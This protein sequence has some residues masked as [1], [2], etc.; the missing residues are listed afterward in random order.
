MV[1][2]TEEEF[3]DLDGCVRKMRT[4]EAA[5]ARIQHTDGKVEEYSDTTAEEWPWAPDD[6]PPEWRLFGIPMLKMFELASRLNDM[7]ISLLS[8]NGEI[9][10]KNRKHR[11]GNADVCR[12][13]GS[14]DGQ[15]DPV[16][17]LR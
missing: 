12:Q 17:Q 3:T 9:I 8:D 1:R 14:P 7:T 16:G 4:I 15:L 10:L 6:R 13:S 5:R 11:D 2:I